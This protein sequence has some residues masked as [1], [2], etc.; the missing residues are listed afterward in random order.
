MHTGAGLPGRSL[1]ILTLGVLLAASALSTGG[2]SIFGGDD[3]EEDEPVELPDFKST[4]KIDKVW[5]AGLGDDTEFLRLALAPASDGSRIFAAAH[6]GQ[7]SAFEAVKGKRLWR[8]ETGLQ[9]SGGP[10]TDGKVVVLGS[11]NGEVIALDAGD[12]R[13]MWRKS[14]SSEV[15]A[16]PAVAPGLALVRTVDGRLTALGIGDGGQ[17]W[18]VQQNMPRLTVRGTGAPVVIG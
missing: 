8:S 6:D 16:A 17:R 13:E 9:L 2:C 15:L 14:L 18:F 11:S 3:D 7:V 12:G 5:S 4:I 1:R 10:A